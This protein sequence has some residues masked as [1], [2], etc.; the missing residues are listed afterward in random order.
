MRSY[1]E[2]L[3]QLVVDHVSLGPTKRSATVKQPSDLDSAAPPGPCS[4][5]KLELAHTGCDL[6]D[7]QILHRLFPNLREVRVREYIDP[8]NYIDD[9]QEAQGIQLEEA[10]ML[11]H[12]LRQAE[13]REGCLESAA[14]SSIVTFIDL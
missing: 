11:Q 2:P 1:S 6:L 7:I 4:L 13:L 10:D 14:L 3:R 8:N 9:H 5:M 12:H